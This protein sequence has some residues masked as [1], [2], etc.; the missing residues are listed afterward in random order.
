MLGRPYPGTPLPQDLPLILQGLTGTLEVPV[1]PSLPLPWPTPPSQALASELVLLQPEAPP[2]HLLGAHRPL[3]PS[4]APVKPASPMGNPC[5]PSS[6]QLPRPQ[7]YLINFPSHIQSHEVLSLLSPKL[8][9]IHPFLP[10]F[11]ATTLEKVTV[12]SS[13]LSGF[14]NLKPSPPTVHFP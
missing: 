9:Q 8:S 14:P 3:H 2:P 4:R 7:N 11:T 5:L 13:L 10:I 6:I 12:N 1:L